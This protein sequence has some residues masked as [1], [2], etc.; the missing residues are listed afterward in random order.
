M[1]SPADFEYQDPL[2]VK[3]PYLSTWVPGYQMNDSAHAQPEFWAGQPL[4]WVSRTTMLSVE[5]DSDS[6]DQIV[7]ARVNGKTYSLFGNPEDVGNTTAA[8][9]ESVSFTSSH[10]FVNLKAG[11][12]NVTLDFFSPVLPRKEDYVRQSLPYSY[13]TVTAGKSKHKLFRA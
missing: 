7:S 9:T 11:A 10:T 4:T 2:A 3:S 1:M 5:P 8:T 13:L 12:A 6:R